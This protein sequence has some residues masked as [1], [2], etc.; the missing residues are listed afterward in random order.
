[1]ANND[2]WQFSQLNKPTALY[3]FK[4]QC[5]GYLFLPPRSA[6]QFLLQVN[7]M[8]H[9]WLS[10]FACIFQCLLSSLLFTF[11]DRFSPIH[12]SIEVCDKAP[13]L[14]Y[15]MMYV[16]RWTFRHRCHLLVNHPSRHNAG[17]L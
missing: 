5:L 12:S 8:K 9:M 13:F 2:Y 7:Y 6:F 10:F 3:L 4:L 1:M 11:H 16:G 15:V 14:C 17:T